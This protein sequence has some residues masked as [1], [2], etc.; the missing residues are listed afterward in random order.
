MDKIVDIQLTNRA[1]RTYGERLEAIDREESD[2]EDTHGMLVGEGCTSNE[3]DC[4]ICK[5]FK[6]I[7]ISLNRLDD[8]RSDLAVKIEDS[9][10]DLESK[11]TALFSNDYIDIEIHLA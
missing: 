8:L 5:Q 1:I 11:I 4:S 10:N 2:L 7:E 3:E 6:Y 9:V